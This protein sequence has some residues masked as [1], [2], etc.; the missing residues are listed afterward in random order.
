MSQS[1]ENISVF[2]EY[3]RPEDRVTAALLHVLNAGGQ[4]ITERLFGNLFDIPSNSISVISQSYQENS[5]PDGE[6]LYDCK[7]NIF[8][9]SKIVPNTINTVQLNNHLQL[10][11]PAENKFLCYI[12]PDLSIPQQLIGLPVGWLSWKDVIDYLSGILA[13]GLADRLLFFLI[14]QLIQL[15]KHVVY[16]E[17]GTNIKDDQ[18]YIPISDDERVIIV[19]G[20][21][22]EEVALNYGFYACQEHRFFMPAKYIAF[23]HHNRI[24]YF[25]EITDVQDSVDIQTI[26]DIAQSNYFTIKEVNYTPQQRKYMKLGSVHTYE[27]EIQNDKVDKNG[28][29]CAFTQGQTY[30]TYTKIATATKT[31]QL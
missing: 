25:F 9:E 24:K 27:P 4:P 10:V 12:T 21:W 17:I 13:D 5:I 11:N 18:S 20:S 26:P 31:S 22:G 28:K 14:G 1:I 16:K 23:Y 30:T 15:I 29:P 2:G 3:R 8:I 6:I 19:G 7:Y